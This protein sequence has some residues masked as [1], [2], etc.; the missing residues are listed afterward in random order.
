MI[1]V[2][3]TWHTTDFLELFLQF[4]KFR[5]P[6]PENRIIA[7]TG[8]LQKRGHFFLIKGEGFRFVCVRTDRQDL[9]AKFT[10]AAK[11]IFRWMRMSKTVF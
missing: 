5:L 1:E 3:R 10:V 2:Y 7:K 9:A 4:H 8:I 11:G 6:A